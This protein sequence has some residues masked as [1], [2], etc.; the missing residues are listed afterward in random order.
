VLFL[1]GLPPG[2]AALSLDQRAEL[3]HLL[4]MTRDLASESRL[5]L[6]ADGIAVASPTWPVNLAHLG[7]TGSVA[8]PD[9][10]LATRMRLEVGGI[11][12]PSLPPGPVRDLLPRHVVLAPYVTGTPVEDIFAMIDQMI[13][14]GADRDAVAR[15]AMRRLAAAPVTIGIDALSL[16]LGPALLDA[17]GAVTVTAPGR[18]DGSALIEATGLD[19]LIREASQNRLLKQGVPVLIFLKGIGDQTGDKVVWNLA[20]RDGAFTVNGTDMS[21]MLPG[22]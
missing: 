5:T 4:A 19:A 22:R 13:D 10:K 20:Y 2:N 15:D 16:D 1:I 17:H 14:D 7:F 11:D 3:H 6:A 12:L 21:G 8:A 18:M 9:G